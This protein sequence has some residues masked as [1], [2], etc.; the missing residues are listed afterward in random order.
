[1]EIKETA[2][3][4]EPA[5]FEP[6][7]A[8]E[9]L[10]PETPEEFAEEAGESVE[11]EILAEQAEEA[12]AQDE[13]LVEIKETAEVEEPAEFEPEDAGETLIA[14]TPEEF[15]EEAGESV[16][17]E[18]H[19]EQAE[20]AEAQEEAAE[21]VEDE[22]LAG[23]AEEAETQDETLEVTEETAETA[24]TEVPVEVE[25]EVPELAEEAE[26]QDETPEVT[27][28]TAEAEESGEDTFDSDMPGYSEMIESSESMGL[29]SIGKDQEDTGVLELDEN[30]ATDVSKL[31]YDLSAEKDGEPV[32]TEE[33][34]AELSGFEDSAKTSDTGSEIDFESETAAGEKSTDLS[35]Q[36]DGTDTGKEEVDPEKAAPVDSYSDL[37]NEEIEGLSTTDSAPDK[38]ENTLEAE[39]KEGIDYSDVLYGQESIEMKETDAAGGFIPS[40]K[41]Q[42]E[43]ESFEVVAPEEISHY[44]T[45]TGSIKDVIS[46]NENI[47]TD[48]SEPG[49][50]ESSALSS[51]SVELIEDM[52]KSSPNFEI[53]EE[54]EKEIADVDKSSLDELIVDYVE[55][56]KKSGKEEGKHPEEDGSPESATVDN[57]ILMDFAGDKP[58]NGTGDAEVSDI[59]DATATMAEIFVSQGLISRALEIYK[60]LVKK[61]PDNE[62]I[63]SRL[64]ELELMI[65]E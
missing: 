41:K 28:E 35:G 42:S 25:P 19:A 65:N 39:T 46:E 53:T 12:E 20:E 4:E 59:E 17:E 33:E 10:I 63:K 38:S 64:E 61:E 16:E 24:E 27:E 6:E 1:M 60:V 34:R 29:D 56:L 43:E 30:E 14:E 62:E 15:A 47:T 9:T 45:E 22:I 37:S 21:S 23:L 54:A 49:E 7:D 44:E 5:E 3:V 18:M 51:D 40:D 31:T 57:E 11:E 8:G 13:T 55:V 48:N 26:A 2:E 36:K 52:I 50:E 32:L 58:L